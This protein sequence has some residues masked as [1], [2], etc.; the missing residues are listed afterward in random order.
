MKPPRVLHVVESLNRG[1][2]ENWLVRMLEHGRASGALMDW[3]FYCILPVTGELEGR[4]RAL[5]AAVIKSPVPITKKLRFVRAMRAEIRKGS[6]EVVHAHHDLLSGIYLIASAGLTLHRRIVHVHNAA[7]HLPT[8]SRFKRLAFSAPLRLLCLRLSDLVVAVSEH[9]LG[10]F[11]D[12]HQRDPNRHMVQYCGVDARD[13]STPAPDR[14]NFRHD[15]KLSANTVILLFA[16]RLVPE[17]NPVFA[18][19]LLSQLRLIYPNT[20]ALFAGVGSEE[21]PIRTRARAL[22]IADSVHILGWRTDLASVMRCADLFVL[23]SPESPMEGFGLAVVEAQ[24][25]GLRLLLSRGIP[26]DPL[27]PSACY[28]RLSLQESPAAWAK[29]AAELLAKG[30]PSP[31]TALAELATSSMDMCRAFQNLN[32]LHT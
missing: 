12:G 31:Q 29:A 20:V 8:S 9:T 14:V 5:G 32:R 2:T 23:P 25:A 15:L 1:A 22:G 10:A 11:L 26:D 17:K 16:G 13:F 19:E 30:A 3:S 7:N 4:V 18:V 6:Y 27:L 21:E 24:L 28:R